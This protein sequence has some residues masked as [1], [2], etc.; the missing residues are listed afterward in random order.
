MKSEFRVSPA[1]AAGELL[2]YGGNIRDTIMAIQRA[3]FL[4]IAFLVLGC[5]GT[6]ENATRVE[7]NFEFER[8]A[9]FVQGL[10]HADRMI[11]H[12]GLP[13][14][15]EAELLATEKRTKSTRVLHGFPFYR[16]ALEVA[17]TDDTEIRRLLG[18]TRSFEKSEG[19]RLCGG[20][21]PDYAIEWRY[22]DGTFRMLICFGCE[23]I[24]V[25]GPDR[26][27]Y[28]VLKNDPAKEVRTILQK[29]RKNRPLARK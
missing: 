16:E 20:F 10:R 14:H 2:R 15:E 25:Y 11:L 24:N 8:N 9:D 19:V 13:H 6:S 7:T 17:S 23:E 1:P 3:S 28:C 22:Q 21:H 27:L 18:D 26:S 5:T 4:L 12:E 29:Y